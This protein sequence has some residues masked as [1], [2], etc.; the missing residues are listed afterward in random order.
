MTRHHD[1]GAEPMSTDKAD[2]NGVDWGDQ[3]WATVAA[4]YLRAQDYRAEK[5]ILH[6]RAAAEALE[7]IGYDFEA[8]GSATSRKINPLLLAV[9]ARQFDR[10][11][12]DFLARHPDAV[13]LHLGCGLDSRNFRLDPGPGVQWFDLDLPDV[14]E[15]RRKV[16]PAA[17]RYETIAAPVIP[18]EWIERIPTGRPTLII[19]EGLMM[20]LSEEEVATLFGDLTERFGRGEVLFDGLAPWVVRLTKSIRWSVRDGHEAE[21]LVPRLRLVERIP[22]TAHHRLMP[23]RKQRIAIR[24]VNLLPAGRRVAQQFRYVF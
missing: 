3:K 9:R 19:A 10:W 23:L 21:R 18:T 11:A 8:L 13:V 2:L 20:L 4:L 16:Y 22:L 24:L 1:E 17:P 5:S 7:R 12:A 6:D 14:I 15:L